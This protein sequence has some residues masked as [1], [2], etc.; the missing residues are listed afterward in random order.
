LKVLRLQP[1][2]KISTS[3]TDFFPIKQMRLQKFDG[4]TWVVFGRRRTAPSSNT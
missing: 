2:V 3:P 1:G 4:K